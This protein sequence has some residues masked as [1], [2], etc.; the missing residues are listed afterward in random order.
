MRLILTMITTL[1]LAELQAQP[2]YYYDNAGNRHTRDACLALIQDH[3]DS[4]IVS[5]ILAARSPD[6]L[7]YQ[8]SLAGLVIYPNPAGNEFM[9]KNQDQWSGAQLMIY[10]DEGKLIKSLTISHSAI[11]VA[12][13]PPA[14]YFLILRRDKF[15]STGKLIKIK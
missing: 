7:I 5:E 9:L 6:G 8:E 2:C 4:M 11:S 15:I 1:L 14:Q 3:N 12:S 13:L 10:T